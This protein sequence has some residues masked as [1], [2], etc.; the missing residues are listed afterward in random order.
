VD[1]EPAI[2]DVTVRMLK[3]NGYTVLSA[4]NGTEALAQYAQHSH[5]VKA[6]ITDLLM[7]EMDGLT[8]VRVLRRIAP[9]IAVIASTGKGQTDTVEE[10]KSLGVRL[11]LYK[12]YSAEKLLDALKKALSPS[13]P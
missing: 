2:R 8:L 13:Q 5:A 10:L 3:Q 9:G 1:D 6:V 12:P 7:P 4:G 11:F